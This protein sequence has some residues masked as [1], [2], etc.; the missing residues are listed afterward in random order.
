MMITFEEMQLPFSL[1]GWLFLC[2]NK[3]MKLFVSSLAPLWIYAALFV[4]TWMAN[5]YCSF[6]SEGKEDLWSEV[7][8]NVPRCCIYFEKNVKTKE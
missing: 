6:I 1:H 2:V 4:R 8:N 7:V 5:C 3:T